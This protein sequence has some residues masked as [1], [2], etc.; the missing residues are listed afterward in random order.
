VS[1]RFSVRLPPTLN[2]PEA[3]EKLK[4]ILL[5]NP[6]YNAK[7]ELCDVRASSGWT[8]PKYDDFLSQAIQDSSKFFYN[9]QSLGLG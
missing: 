2:G 4:Q 7:V 3:A 9:A 8:S 5:V 6:P 1:I